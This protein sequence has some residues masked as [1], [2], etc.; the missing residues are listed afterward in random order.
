[1]T[2]SQ[3]KGSI[4]PQPQTQGLH[5]KFRERQFS[6]QASICA[7]TIVVLPQKSSK[8]LQPHKGRFRIA[9]GVVELM[10][11]LFSC[12]IRATED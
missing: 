10:T 9:L 12:E 5:L 11:A 8:T 2:R 4:R 6:Q 1:M 7:L 3:D